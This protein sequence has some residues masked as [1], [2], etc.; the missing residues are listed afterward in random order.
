MKQYKFEDK[1][2]AL[3]QLDSW[4]N[5]RSVVLEFYYNHQSRYSG[6]DIGMNVI[7]KRIERL[8][9]NWIKIRDN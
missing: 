9:M 1:L 6:K 7:F 8:F 4:R 3:K 2:W 5:K